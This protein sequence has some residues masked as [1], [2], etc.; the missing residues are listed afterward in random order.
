MTAPGTTTTPTASA[1]RV[2]PFLGE[3]TWSY[4][5]RLADAHHLTASRLLTAL[6]I[7][8]PAV[9]RA[10]LTREIHLSAGA[11]WAVAT[12]CGLT[13]TQLSKTLPAWRSGEGPH[14]QGNRSALFQTPAHL[15][16]AACARCAARY[17]P[18]SRITAYG[19]YLGLL[20]RK[21]GQWTLGRQTING[22]PVNADYAD[23]H[24]APEIPAALRHLRRD[25]RLYSSYWHFASVP[26]VNCAY[27]AVTYWWLE[28]RDHDAVWRDRAQRLTPAR[29]DSDLWAVAAREPVT[30]PET[31][32][33]AAIIQ[34]YQTI[35][36]P[37]RYRSGE[38]HPGWERRLAKAEA[39]LR[40]DVIAALDR[41]WLT[42]ASM[43]RLDLL[44]RSYQPL[45]Q[46]KCTN[47]LHKGLPQIRPLELSALGLGS[48]PARNAV[49]RIWS[50]Y[51][52]IHDPCHSDD[53]PLR[54]RDT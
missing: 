41:P 9:P 44:E 20:C 24:A 11:K 30:L 34:R 47:A 14:Q 17:Q 21:H 39:A 25:R 8:H 18:G 31:I 50:A 42:P 28:H 7:D 38:E 4:L 49:T 26:A 40:R 46:R 27:A 6:G 35:L 13:D 32:R 29:G 15:P 10:G 51:S 1:V 43:A 2:R 54:P 22:T 23:L 3:T 52:H 53:L 36:R 12:L 48:P 45:F 16:A 33:V 5:N 37:L 19:T